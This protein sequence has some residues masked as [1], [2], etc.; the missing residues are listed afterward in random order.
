MEP[1]LTWVK[2][3]DN[4]DGEFPGPAAREI[5]IREPRPLDFIWGTKAEADY[6]VWRLVGPQ[7]QILAVGRAGPAPSPAE[8]GFFDIDLRKHLPTQPPNSAEV[9]RIQVQPRKKMV[10]MPGAM[11]GSSTK[12]PSQAVG[13]W[14]TSA[15]ILYGEG[16]EPP[17]QTKFKRH[18]Q[19]CYFVLESIRMIQDQS[20]PGDE[21]FYL[22]GFVQQFTPNGVQQKKI[23]AS[24]T[25]DPGDDEFEAFNKRYTFDSPGVYPYPW[26]PRTHVALI[27]IMEKDG[28]DNMAQWMAD[29]SKI[30][31]E[32]ISDAV[33]DAVNDLLEELENEL[34]EAIEEALAGLQDDIIDAAKEAAAELAE[35]I[36]SRVLDFLEEAA[37]LAV[38]AVIVTAIVC[39]GKLIAS[40]LEDDLYTPFFDDPLFALTIPTMHEDYIESLKGHVHAGNSYRIAPQ[41]IEYHGVPDGNYAGAWDGK[42]ELTVRWDFEEKEEELR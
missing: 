41:S 28:G 12:V 33:K 3:G 15:S 40:G 11:H 24:T 18:Y 37:T 8:N 34:T 5:S 14:S 7:S 22:R 21:E 29:V 39:I 26:T 25:L 42:V 17:S 9:Y 38:V 32:A 16:Y 19:K 23:R 13:V 31:E 6:G 30:A 35:D 4:L 1:T 36:A 10:T 2:V 27:S 20:G